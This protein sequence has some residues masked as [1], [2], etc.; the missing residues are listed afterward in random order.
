MF[1]VS[2]SITFFI[3]CRINNYNYIQV[4][5]CP[6]AFC[7]G[8]GYVTAQWKKTRSSPTARIITTTDH[9]RR[10]KSTACGAPSTN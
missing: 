3:S 7:P 8:F 4:A 6:V 1:N 5:L 9:Q 10:S 2:K